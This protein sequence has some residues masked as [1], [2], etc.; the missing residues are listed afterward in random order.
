[1]YD[2]LLTTDQDMILLGTRQYA[3]ARL[4][5][6]WRVVTIDPES[7]LTMHSLGARYSKSLV[8][9]VCVLQ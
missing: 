6:E 5:G 3:C 2:R 9:L 8:F 7:I 4:D 1:V